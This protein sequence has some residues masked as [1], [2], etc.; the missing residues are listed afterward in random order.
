MTN[1]IELSGVI[2]QPP[3]RKESPAGIPHCRFMLEHRSMMQEAQLPR[4]VYCRMAVVASGL[5]SHAF[6]HEL[7]LGSNVKVS[8]FLNYQQSQNGLAHLVLHADHITQI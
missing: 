1:R 3:L 7:T 8:G 6:T 2:T 4:Q 5:Q